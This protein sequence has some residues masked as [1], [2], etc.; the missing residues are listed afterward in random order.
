MAQW[1]QAGLEDLL[2]KWQ[3]L[4]HAVGTLV[5]TSDDDGEKITGEFAGLETDG[6]LRLRKSDGTLIA[7]RAGDV[8]IG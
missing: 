4:A 7:I 6:A 8:S 2:G 1:R 3:N 5:T